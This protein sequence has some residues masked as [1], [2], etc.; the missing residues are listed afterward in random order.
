MRSAEALMRNLAD[1]ALVHAL[2]SPVTKC[3]YYTPPVSAVVSLPIGWQAS[4]ALVLAW[5]NE[6]AQRAL[7]NRI[8]TSGVTCHAAKQDCFA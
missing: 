5:F 7:R 3:C 1:G 2:R 6:V 8:P 4:L